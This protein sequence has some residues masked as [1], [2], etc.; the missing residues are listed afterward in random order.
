SFTA[1]DRTPCRVLRATRAV[2]GSRLAMARL[3]PCRVYAGHREACPGGRR[4]LLGLQLQLA[5]H[6]RSAHHARAGFRRRNANVAAVP[7]GQ[8]LACS[9]RSRFRGVA[10]ACVRTRW[11]LYGAAGRIPE[12]R[13][14]EHTSELQSREN[15]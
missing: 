11:S 10:P 13:S 7:A 3:E 4:R 5:A 1:A 14:E 6:G 12:S 2:A 15:L 9:I 8:R